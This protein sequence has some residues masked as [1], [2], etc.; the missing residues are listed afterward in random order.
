MK[1]QTEKQHRER[2]VELHK[3]LDELFADYISHHPDMI[4]FTET[5]LKDLL[6]WSYEQ[7]KY[8]TN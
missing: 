5:P 6:Q 7:T 1:K 3:C 8:P 4:K 2:H